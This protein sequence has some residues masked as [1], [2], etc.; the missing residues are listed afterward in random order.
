MKV[1]PFYAVLLLILAVAAGSLGAFATNR[2][3]AQEDTSRGMHDF[4][5]KELRLTSA[6]EVRLGALE[7]NFAIEH[8]KLEL[9]L[10]SA[11][12]GLAE[13]M[14]EE[15][16]YGPKV[17]AEIDEVHARMGD[18]QKA[19]VRHVFD[20]RALLDPAQQKAFDREVSKALTSDPKS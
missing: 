6:Q 9:A 4:V 8:R 5:H 13:A 11:N 2:W 17:A 1:T 7:R 3:L 19:T 14:S 16:R 12:A 20:M 18:L 10:R 15:Q